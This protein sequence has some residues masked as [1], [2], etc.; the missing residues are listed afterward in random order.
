MIKQTMYVSIL[1][2]LTIMFAFSVSACSCIQPQSPTKALENADVVFSGTVEKVTTAS[3]GSSINSVTYTF[4]RGNIWKGPESVMIE[5]KTASN[6]A[7]CGVNLEEGK[8]YLVYAYYAEDESGKQE[9]TT[10]LC[11]RTALLVDAANDISELNGVKN[12]HEPNEKPAENN[13][14]GNSNYGS[15][16]TGFWSHFWTSIRNWFKR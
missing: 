3:F 13:V 7:A 6:S 2:V 9:L 16:E 11:S 5:V 15:S 1:I 8:E 10:T 4:K 14:T 12:S